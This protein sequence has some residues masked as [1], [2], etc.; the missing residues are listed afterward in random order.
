MLRDKVELLGVYCSYIQSDYLHKLIDVLKQLFDKEKVE[1][2]FSG[3]LSTGKTTI[4]NRLIDKNILPTGIGTTTR[5]INFIFY[6]K[7]NEIEALYKDRT[8]KTFP[9]SEDSITKINNDENI[10]AIYIKTSEFPY[11]TVSFTDTPGIDD[12]EENLEKLTLSRV[13]YAD[14]II[15]VLDASKGLTN[16]DKSFFDNYVVKYM[17]DKI[18]IFFNKMDAV[19][20]EI[21][22]EDIQKIKHDLNDYP[23]FF[24]SAKL[25][26]EGFI[27]FKSSVE[28]YLKNTTKTNNLKRR[29]KQILNSIQ[30]VADSY[31]RLKKEYIGKSKAELEQKLAELNERKKLFKEKMAELEKEVEREISRNIEKIDEVCE[32]YSEII[33]GEISRIDPDYLKEYFY[34]GTFQNR[35]RELIKEI[36]SN[37]SVQLEDIDLS[38]GSKLVL[39]VI[40]WLGILDPFFENLDIPDIS[41]FIQNFMRGLSK[42]VIISDVKKII[43]RIYE[44][45]VGNLRANL[46]EYFE[47]IMD[48]SNDDITM[49]LSAVLNSLKYI[50]S[51][52]DDL[53]KEIEQV[54][55]N[56]NEIKNLTT[57]LINEIDKS[58][59]I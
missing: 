37:V 7:S 9:I 26:D 25:C 50:E 57:L 4:I 12:L 21:S 43:N 15:F 39:T 31:L 55:R 10:E 42:G 36:G 53:E 17:R 33:I 34:N 38:A 49:E 2:L 6:D 16:K 27:N 20:D 11:L 52:K 28:N 56:V 41:D 14:A 18:F 44:D 8:S 59:I 1:I 32:K 47:N 5:T 24:G 19:A 13:P 30:E 22:Q 40:D 23:V 46:N 29:G 51:S 3:K 58:E 45:A 54:T 48:R 35:L